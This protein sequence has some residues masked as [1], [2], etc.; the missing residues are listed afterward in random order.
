MT[1]PGRVLVC[2]AAVATLLTACTSHAASSHPAA[3][4]APAAVTTRSGGTSPAPGEASLSCQQSINAMPAVPTGYSVVLGVVAL[5]T[6][7]VLQANAAGKGAPETLFAKQGL[8]VRAGAVFD[9]EVAPGWAAPA[10]I[11]WGSPATPG[12]RLHVD[13]CAGQDTWLAY[14]GGYWVDKPACL[15]LIVRA[16]GQQETVNISVGVQCP[17]S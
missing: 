3:T 9:L 4:P 16:D 7:R 14:A 2:V 11:G 5:P 1:R 6:G 8:V 15:P 10:R 12:P 13:A 17:A